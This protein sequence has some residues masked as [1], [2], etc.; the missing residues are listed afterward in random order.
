MIQKMYECET[1]LLFVENAAKVTRWVVR[2]VK[3]IDDTRDLRCVH[4]R[5]KV[6]VRRQ[7][8]PNGSGNHVDHVSSD[9][10]KHCRA[11]RHFKGEHRASLDP[12]L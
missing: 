8:T 11:G 12:A 4:C 6:R 7:K 9:D 3:G 2:P 5:G 1:R 10:S